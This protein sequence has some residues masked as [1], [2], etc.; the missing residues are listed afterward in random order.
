M[1]SKNP[2]HKKEACIT[3][4]LTAKTSKRFKCSKGEKE[5]WY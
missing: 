5:T 2:K 1:R 3:K 4:I